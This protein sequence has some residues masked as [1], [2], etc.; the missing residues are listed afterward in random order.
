MQKKF[1]LKKLSLYKKFFVFKKYFIVKF[2]MTGISN[3]N[4][5]NFIEENTNDDI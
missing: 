4:I 2:T 3:Q 1:F 5:L